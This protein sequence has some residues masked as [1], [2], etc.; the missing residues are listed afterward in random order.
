MTS[1]TRYG[2]AHYAEVQHCHSSDLWPLFASIKF[3]RAFIVYDLV[4][5]ASPETRAN[6]PTPADRSFRASVRPVASLPEL[7]RHRLLHRGENRSGSIIVYGVTELGET[8]A[9]RISGV[10]LATV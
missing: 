9:P 1:Y 4:T 3:A 7:Q 2:A 10:P 8:L 6:S 5:S